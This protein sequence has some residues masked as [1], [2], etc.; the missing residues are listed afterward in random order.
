MEM[1]KALLSWELSGIIAICLVV[2]ASAVP[3]AEARTPRTV[4]SQP[5]SPLSGYLRAEPEQDENEAF[6]SELPQVQS[7]K[8]RLAKVKHFLKGEKARDAVYLGMWSE[9][10][11]T[12][13]DYEE[14][15]RLAAIQY[16]GLYAGTFRNSHS[17]QTYMMGVA[18]TL[19]KK[20][21]GENL[22][23]DAGYKVGPMYGYK[24]GVPTI[25]GWSVLPFVTAGVSYKALGADVNYI[26]FTN[27]GSINTR[28][29][30]TDLMERH[31][32][33]QAA[34]DAQ[35]QQQPSPVAGEPDG[36]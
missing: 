18:R 21:I 29:N 35:P 5:V 31:K 16:N 36:N 20:S 7:P 12:S 26:P 1:K 14:N 32:Q 11:G 10:F 30:L 24:R 33:K 27:V 9:H 25:G 23:L 17:D 6:V 28:V 2:C 34:S 22:E 15:N 4:Q 13:K 3:L 19:A 8:G